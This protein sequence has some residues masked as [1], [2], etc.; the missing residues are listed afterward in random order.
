MPIDSTELYK[1]NPIHQKL[2]GA[3]SQYGV[4]SWIISSIV[5]HESKFN[6]NAH[7]DIGLGA[8]GSWGLFQLYTG[9]GH[10]KG[11]T[12]AQLQDPDTNINI[13]M[14]HLQKGYK[15][16]KSKGLT[17]F[18]LLKETAAS[19]GWPLMTGAKNMPASYENGLRHTY[20]NGDELSGLKGTQIKDY[21]LDYPVAEHSIWT[22]G[23]TDRIDPILLGRLAMLGKTYNEKVVIGSGFRSYEEQVILYNLYKSGKGNLAAVPGTSNHEKGLAVDIDNLKFKLLPESV[24]KKFGLH[25]PVSGENWHIEKLSGGNNGSINFD[26]TAKEIIRNGFD[27]MNIDDLS[28]GSYSLFRGIDKISGMGEGLNGELTD[29]FGVH[30]LVESSGKA[31]VFRAAVIIIG[32]VLIIASLRSVA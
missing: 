22:T 14:K 17:G 2:K 27:L 19:S 13:A 11:Y 12:A 26:N 8:S 21:Q 30:R 15:G 31:I 29:G 32:L 10:G 5:E 4:P 20:E 28:Q 1:P 24:F 16:A 18:D 23:K 9:N 3:S 25:R 7:G 6:P